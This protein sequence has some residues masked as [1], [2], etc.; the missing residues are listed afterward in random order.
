MAGCCLSVGKKTVKDPSL[1][2]LKLNLGRH[3]ALKGELREGRERID[4]AKRGLNLNKK[5]PPDNQFCT[6]TMRPDMSPPAIMPFV[7]KMNGVPMQL[8]PRERLGKRYPRQPFPGPQSPMQPFPIQPFPMQ[9]FPGQ[10]LPG[11]PFPMQPFGPRPANQG[12][13]GRLQKPPRR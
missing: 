3:T 7:M 6:R 11:Y 2:G 4:P 9:L 10:P 1:L 13:Y 5:M 8:S 12:K